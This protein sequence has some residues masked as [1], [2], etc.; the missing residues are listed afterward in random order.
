MGGPVGPVWVYDRLIWE[1][2]AHGARAAPAAST[3]A[4]FS[5]ATTRSRAQQ[6]AKVRTPKSTHPG[7]T[8]VTKAKHPWNAECCMDTT[9]LGSLTICSW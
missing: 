6:S 4:P 1:R 9:V 5:V 3:L 8:T 2:F 7:T